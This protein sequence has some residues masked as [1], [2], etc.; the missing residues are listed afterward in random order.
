MRSMMIVMALCAVAR[1][2]V[3]EKEL[4]VRAAPA[5]AT[6]RDGGMD[7]DVVARLGE[8]E[9]DAERVA[10]AELDRVIERAL[11]T[12]ESEDPFSIAQRPAARPRTSAVLTKIS[13]RARAAG[14]LVISARALD[15]RWAISE[16]Q[17]DPQLA[18]VL[19]TW[20]E[21]DADA[22]P[23]RA[24]YLAR[25]ARTADPDSR[26]ALELDDRLTYNH[27]MLTGKLAIVAGAV[28]VVAGAYLQ[29]KVGKIEEDLQAHPRS[30]ADVESALATRD[31]YDLIGTGLLIAGPVVSFGGIAWML[32][33]NPSYTPTSPGELPALGA[34]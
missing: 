15:A 9:R 26:H 22:Q 24:L 18:E 28:A 13:E 16:G 7:P 32:A 8:V 1:A 10:P 20:A 21:R 30:G 2:A 17:H 33:G 12:Y 34:R 5:I 23:G 27:H 6:T 4:E 31:R 29:W 25:R 3:P 14:E 19:T 11:V